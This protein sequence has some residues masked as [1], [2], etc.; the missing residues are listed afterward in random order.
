[1]ACIALSVRTA[2]HGPT[3]SRRMSPQARADR[4]AA[5]EAV[6][7]APVSR[8]SDVTR[9]KRPANGEASGKGGGNVRL[10]VPMRAAAGVG[11]SDRLLGPR[12]KARPAHGRD[13]AS[14]A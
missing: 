3:L 10:V 6:S 2:L 5:A 8:G 7:H 1:M 14:A 11:V 12:L 13:C 4:E 9:G